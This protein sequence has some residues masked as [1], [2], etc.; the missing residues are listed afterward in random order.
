[1]SLDELSTNPESKSV[2]EQPKAPQE[3]PQDMWTFKNTTEKLPHGLDP[4]GSKFIRIGRHEKFPT[5]QIFLVSLEQFDNSFFSVKQ[6]GVKKH[7]MDMVEEPEDL[8]RGNF[9]NGCMRYYDARDKKTHQWP[10]ARHKQFH[11][12]V[13]IIL[14]ALQAVA[15][16]PVLDRNKRGRGKAAPV[17]FSEELN[18][19]G[20]LSTVRQVVQAPHLD[21]KTTAVD[22]HRKLAL[23]NNLP[24]SV[25]PWNMIMSFVKT[26]TRMIFVHGVAGHPT[27]SPVP[28][29]CNVPWKTVLLFR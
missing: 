5:D 3:A 10:L 19:C 18:G 11:L 21:A 13:D 7:Y 25:M 8:Y 1:M 16:V 29:L 9:H 15:R 23:Q 27:F 2:H 24:E 12:F 26:D 17:D 20:F 4:S 6:K 14:K 28:H 22:R